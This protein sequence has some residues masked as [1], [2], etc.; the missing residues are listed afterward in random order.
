MT[1]SAP[2]LIFI[3]T[4]LLIAVQPV[5]FLHLNRPAASLLGAVAM[6]VLGRLP[7][8][9]AYAAID[10]DV[11]VFLLGLMILVGYLEE[12]GFFEAAAEWLL[13]RVTTPRKLLVGVLVGSGLLSALFVNDTICL[14]VTPVLIATIGSLGVRPAPY[15]IALAM[16]ANVG[17]VLAFTGNPQNMLIGLW[18]GIPFARFTLH[19]LPVVAGALALTCGVLL[20]IYRQELSRPFP[21]CVELPPVTVDRSLVV[22]AL[23]LFAGA[24]VAWLLGANLPLVAITAGTL[25]IALAGRDPA[26][27]LARVEWSL[28][29]LFGAL[30]VVMRGLERSGAIGLI[31]AEGSHAISL[32]S[33]WT[34]ALAVSGVMLT[35]SNL[36]SNVPAVILWRHV[37]PDLPHPELM[38]QLMAMSA[39][40]AG[41]LLMIGSA[42]NLIVAER[43][44]ARGVKLGYGEYARAGLPVTLLTVAWGILVLVALEH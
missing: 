28:L 11:L 18:S 17:S 34:A 15:L 39:T 10:L 29:L 4:Y 19:M 43:A 7:L 35:L 8:A 41:N 33:P 6:V 38:W 1:A 14:V 40:F 42:A 31:S 3:I 37:V 22:T 20:A 27:A 23:V 21:R 9:E 24:V 12:G 30:F 44:Q 25:M 5:R 16:G 2:I 32:G 26:P 36:I 13:E